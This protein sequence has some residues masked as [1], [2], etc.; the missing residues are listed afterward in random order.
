MLKRVLNGIAM[1]LD[2]NTNS[3]RQEFSFKDPDGYFI[4]VAEFHIYEG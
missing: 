2:L 3:F 1:Y 4:T